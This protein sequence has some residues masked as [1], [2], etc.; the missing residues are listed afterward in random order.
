MFSRPSPQNRP[1]SPSCLRG[2][3]CLAAALSA[4]ACA[5]AGGRMPTAPPVLA[6]AV[7]GTEVLLQAVSPVTEDV[8]WA[9][10]RGATWVRTTDGGGSW[11]SGSVPGP[12]TL[13]LRD[14]HALDARTA[15]VL[16]SGTGE[17][18]R[19]YR[20]DDG[21][22]TWSL[23]WVNPEPSGFWDCID[24]W[25]RSRGLAY[26]DAVD[27][28]LR[29]LVTGDGGAT[30][31]RV[32]GDGLPDALPDE[33]GFAASGLC[34]DAGSD[35]RAWIAAGNTGTARVFR[36][37]DGGH[38]WR[39]APAPVETGTMA[40]LTAVSMADDRR[41]YAFGGDI[42]RTDEFTRNV[43]ETR[44]GGATWTPLPPLSFPGA[45]YGGL[46]VPGTDGRVLVA[47]GPGGAAVSLDSGH[48]WTTIDERSWWAVG[49]RGL[50]STWIV[51]PEGRIAR[52][53][54]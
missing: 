9:S 48:R 24:F 35:G 40:G 14:I 10:G 34:V 22:G 52:L 18:S 49:S 13:Q 28:E 31:E 44:D 38:S 21:G 25:D 8:V 54:W 41:G 46:S 36:T 16:T 12:D 45:A 27:G 11:Q 42:G 39:P 2:L 1:P 33:G 7:S 4:A 17:L 47:V 37:E 5:H 29:I 23:Q 15:W 51:G 6:E 19:I 20:T 32:S 3:A 53:D 30:W 50:D 43:V 26:G